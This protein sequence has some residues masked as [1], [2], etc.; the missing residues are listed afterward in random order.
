[1]NDAAPVHYN[2]AHD[3]MERWAGERPDDLAL[4]WVAEHGQAEQKFT[5]GEIGRELRQA[6]AFFSALGIRRGDRVL[7]ILQ[8]VPAW[9]MAMLGLIRLGAVP[10][11]GTPLLTAKD[12]AYRKKVAAVRAII[13]DEA[14]AAKTGNFNG[15]RILAGS[16]APGWINFEQGVQQAVAPPPYEP[17]RSDD[18]G[19]IYFTS[20]TTGDAK[21][22]LH[23]QASYGLGH[24]VTG[25]HWLDLG[26]RDMVWALA[27]TGWG[28][29]AWSN[30]FGPWLMGAAVFT[31]DMRSKF[32]P[33]VVLKTLEHYPITV[34]CC[35]ATALRLMVR[36][37]LSAYRFP[38]LRHCVSAG[39][40]LNPPVY[41]AWKK[42]TGL[43]M[44][45]G[46]GQTETVLMVGNFR[47]EGHEIRPGSMGRAAPGFDLAIVD[48]DG[49]E[50]PRGQAG[51]LAIRVQPQRPLGMFREYWR[52]PEETASRFI[53]PWYLTGD[54]AR[55][56]ADGYFWFV[57]RADDV[58]NSS[59]YRIGP[60]EVESALQEH[61][62]VLESAVIGVPEELRGEV[63][64]AFIVLRDGYAASEQL[65]H[66]IQ[67][68]CK[69][70]TAPYKYPRLIEF[71]DALPKTISGKVRRTELRAR[72]R[73]AQKS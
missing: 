28:K 7:V 39:E 40:A 59:S 2:F 66:E 68:H 49:H 10:I 26:P 63:V 32:D 14:G 62:A 46:Y 50:V 1:M 18:P 15:L 54:T 25:G 58:I 57:G 30:F 34:F 24:R 55:Q 47:C 22:V 64:K 4:W 27:D 65:Q 51:Q 72:E 48:E 52:N 35:P 43:S 13:T 60:S 19:I 56:D 16:E 6:A 69:R 23:T 8:R 17:S 45:E 71:V 73:Q 29:T 67:V 21:M 38:H 20:G 5:F 37:D 12:I 61:P 42:A 9:W 11:P 33:G 31:L 3:V 70:V 53:G 36:K 44:Y 41:E